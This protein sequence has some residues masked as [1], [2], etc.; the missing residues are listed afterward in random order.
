MLA[1]LLSSAFRPFYLLGAFYAVLLTAA[2]LGAYLGA[3]EVPSVGKIGRA[4]V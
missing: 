3:W 2:W 1:P 4:H